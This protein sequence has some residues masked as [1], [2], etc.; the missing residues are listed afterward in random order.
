MGAIERETLITWTDFAI[1]LFERTKTKI[2]TL[3]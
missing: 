3:K 2:I 1:R